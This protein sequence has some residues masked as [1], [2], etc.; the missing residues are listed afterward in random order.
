MKKSLRLS[1][2]LLGFMLFGYLQQ[3]QAT[4][5]YVD[6]DYG[7]DAANGLATT[8]SWKNIPGTK[9]AGNGSFLSAGGWKRLVAGDVV[10]VK[11]GSKH[12]SQGGGMIQIDS[13]WYDNGTASSPVTIKGDPSWG[14]G[15][16]VIDGSGITVPNWA[17]LVNISKRDYI[18]FDGGANGIKVQNSGYNGFQTTGNYNTL[19]N[20]EVYNSI[21]ANVIFVSPSYPTTFL[22]GATIDR[23][24]A[25][26]TGINDD[27]AANIFL[28]YVNN[29]VIS[30]CT[31]YD[32]NTGSDGIHLGSC[33]NSWVLN[34][35][36]HNNGEQGV[37]VS[38][39][40][41]NK[42]RDDSWNVTVR[43]CIGYSNYKQNFDSNSSSRDI[44]FINNTAWDTAESEKGDGNF[45]V[46]EGGSRVFFINN[47][48]AA[49]NDFGYG[50]AW[51]G[52][53]Y[54]L[55]SGTYNIY[56][57][58]NISSAD[59]GKSVS[60]ENDYSGRSF[61]VKYYNCLFNSAY[62]GYVVTDKS[63]NYT[64]SSVANSTGG[65]TGSACMS[66][67]PYYTLLGSNWDTT[68]LQLQS[69]S[70]ALNKGVFPFTTSASGSGTTITLN[71]L[72]TDIDARMVFRPG[73]TIQIEG[74]GRYQIASV[75]SS[76]QITL[77]TSATWQSGKGVWMPWPNQKLDIGVIK[78]P[79]TTVKIP[80]APVL[81]SAS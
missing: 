37:D 15:Q 72:V 35:I 6:F 81:L 19:R 20:V 23:V 26:K 17:G 3:A 7:S 2:M 78:A 1:M 54:N 40:G 34:C 75:P 32:S 62:G 64:S 79:T 13:T 14:S 74:S 44:Y 49:S 80:S 28:T 8:S 21:W 47:T 48:S 57:I 73:D 38:K 10:I 31:A 52:G 16:S 33:T 18:V 53:Y 65:W 27:W 12:T 24:V 39:D 41:D 58:N 4:T 69:S 70:P 55:A 68:N 66:T 63:A 67:D 71:K 60:V 43:D 50:I 45:Q 30:N 25:H 11:G 36:V 59:S 61:A 76:N 5:Y 51:W 29:A 22:Q 9:T 46:Y 77:T 56:L 42:N